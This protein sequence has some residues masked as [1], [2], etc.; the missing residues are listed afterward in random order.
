MKDKIMK[1]TDFFVEESLIFASRNPMQK[2]G[3][4]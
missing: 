1:I 3:R 4:I 2:K